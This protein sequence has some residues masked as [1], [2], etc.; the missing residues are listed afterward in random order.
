MSWTS[1]PAS[2]VNYNALPYAQLLTVKP[3]GLSAVDNIIV[4][5]RLLQ[6]WQG[7]KE[8]LTEA[9]A[10]EILFRN[11]VV[12][13]ATDPKKEKG[14]V[15]VELGNGWKM[16]AVK[17]INVSFIK[18]AEGKTDRAAIDRAL[19]KI[20]ADEGN[21]V[22]TERLVKWTPS[23]SESEYKLLSPKYQKAIDAVLVKTPGTPTLEIVAP[24]A[25][26]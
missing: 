12:N 11:A 15:N 1:A 23:L 6:G 3:D 18:N 14:T 5:D 9:Q 4:R 24:K 10:N 13:F 21:D 19:A 25:T 16:K 8:S 17:K 22:I 20:E 26:V 7:S 2:A